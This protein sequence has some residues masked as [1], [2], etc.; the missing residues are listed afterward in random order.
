MT[1]SLVRLR[2]LSSLSVCKRRNLRDND[3]NS[4]VMKC[5]KM[6][7][8]RKINVDMNGKLIIHNTSTIFHSL[9]VQNAFKIIL[10]PLPYC[11]WK[12]NPPSL[13]SLFSHSY[14]PRSLSFLTSYQNSSLFLM[15]FSLK[16]PTKLFIH[17]NLIFIF[18][19]LPTYLSI[20]TT[21]YFPSYRG[22]AHTRCQHTRTHTMKCLPS[23]LLGS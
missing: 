4:K 23:C 22:R 10:S 3:S 8:G 20:H 19:N 5:L 7:D 18:L 2:Q 12:S 14:P 21:T 15:S 17:S 9:Y 16:F 6:I 13:P 1:N 11:S